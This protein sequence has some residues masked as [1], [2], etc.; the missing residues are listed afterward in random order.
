MRQ[1]RTALYIAISIGVIIM[2]LFVIFNTESTPLPTNE[3]TPSDNETPGITQ[4]TYTNEKYG[5]AFDYPSDWQIFENKTIPVINVYKKTETEPPPFTF[6]T[7]V[8]AVSFFPQG[9]GTEGIIGKTEPS[10][11][12]FREE[13]KSA[14]E[15][16]MA[17]GSRWTTFVHFK[18]PSPQ[19]GEFGF[20]AART[21]ISGLT[22]KCMEGETEV[23]LDK[24]YSFEIGADAY[25]LMRSGTLDQ[26]G[27]AVQEK[28]LASFRFL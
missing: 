3:P 9:I 13:I 23:D 4:K 5:F 27:R 17:D 28:V 19:W 2:A 11:I 20:V 12:T 1:K 22:E 10:A 8:T 24:C 26:E 21:A 16:V 25:T 15:H 18:N 6:H 7:P 14:F